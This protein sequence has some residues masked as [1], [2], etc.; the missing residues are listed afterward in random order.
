ML[1]FVKK[2]FQYY[3]FVYICIEFKNKD[4]RTIVKHIKKQLEQSSI[5]PCKVI[6]LPTG[7]TCMHFK[8]G[9]IKVL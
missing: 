6:T 7:V 2:F 3:F 9:K 8:N 5:L 4:M 1:K